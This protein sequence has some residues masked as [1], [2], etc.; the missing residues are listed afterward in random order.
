MSIINKQSVGIPFSIPDGDLSHTLVMQQS[1]LG[2]S[3][4]SPHL[5]D[6]RVVNK[7]SSLEWMRT[8]RK[9]NSLHTNKI[10]V[11]PYYRQFNSH[12]F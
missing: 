5:K 2:M 11:K 9:I 6:V 8:S 12:R 4:L 10:Q 1:R 7:G 3:V